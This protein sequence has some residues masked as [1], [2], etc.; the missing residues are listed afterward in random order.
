MI[1]NNYATSEEFC[2][3]AFKQVK[4][5]VAQTKHVSGCEE[6]WVRTLLIGLKEAMWKPVLYVV[7][8]WDMDIEVFPQEYKTTKKD[9]EFC[10]RMFDR[11]FAMNASGEGTPIRFFVLGPSSC[12]SD[13]GKPVSDQD[14]KGFSIIS[15]VPEEYVRNF[16][17]RIFG[18]DED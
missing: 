15:D 12:L 1:T 11:L 8:E 9:R 6:T 3:E 10:Q 7:E 14:K 5:A 16:L 4:E 18:T 17:P 13:D 2:L